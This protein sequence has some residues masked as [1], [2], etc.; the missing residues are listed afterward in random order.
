[1][2]IYIYIYIYIFRGGAPRDL[3]FHQVYSFKTSSL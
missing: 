3:Q 2:Y 1:M